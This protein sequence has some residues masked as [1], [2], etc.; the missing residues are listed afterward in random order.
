[1]GALETALR[2]PLTLLSCENKGNALQHLHLE[3]LRPL[4]FLPG[5]LHGTSCQVFLLQVSAP[6]CALAS[7]ICNCFLDDPSGSGDRRA[8]TPVD[9]GL[10]SVPGSSRSSLSLKALP[11]MFSSFAHA[12]TVS[13]SLGSGQQLL[14]VTLSVTFPRSS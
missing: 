14:Q 8:S 4:L 6:P 13:V 10:H 3:P 7:L 1:M 5:L 2:G 12:V 11:S 9:L